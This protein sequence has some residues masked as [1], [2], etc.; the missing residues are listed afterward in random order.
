MIITKISIQNTIPKSDYNTTDYNIQK[1]TKMNDYNILQTTKIYD[2][3][4]QQ[5]LK[6]KHSIEK[7]Q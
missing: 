5:L 4:V 2:Y 6:C 3:G 7:H 1:T